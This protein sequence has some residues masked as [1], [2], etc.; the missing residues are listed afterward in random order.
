MNNARPGN[1]TFAYDGISSKDGV[2]WQMETAIHEG[3]D[4]GMGIPTIH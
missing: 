3:V 4:A 2:A 1:R